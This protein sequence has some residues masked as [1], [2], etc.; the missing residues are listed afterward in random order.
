MDWEDYESGPFCRHWAEASACYI[1][2]AHCGHDCVAH[3]VGDDTS[4]SVDNCACEEWQDG[5]DKDD[6][7]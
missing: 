2:C 6:E 5:P 1:I 3:N 4:C 7:Q